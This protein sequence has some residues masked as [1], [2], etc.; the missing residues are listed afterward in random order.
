MKN[1]IIIRE[2]LIHLIRSLLKIK[3][4]QIKMIFTLHLLMKLAIKMKEM[5]QFN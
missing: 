5:S 1:Q 2:I 4:N 3:I